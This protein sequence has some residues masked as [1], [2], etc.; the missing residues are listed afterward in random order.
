MPLLAKEEHQR[1]RQLAAWSSRLLPD[2]LH[3]SEYQILKGH[4]TNAQSAIYLTIR[5]DILRLWTRN[6]LVHVSVNEIL[7]RIKDKR[8]HSLVI[9][10]HEW[11]ARH[12]YINFGCIHIWPTINR[13]SASPAKQQRIVIIGAGVSGLSTARQLTNIILQFPER[14]CRDRTQM[15]PRL[16]ILE[17]RQ[18]IGGRVYSHALKNQVPGSLPHGLANTA[19]MGAQIITGFH[20]GNPLD[21]LVRGQLTLEYHLMKDNMMLYDFDG[22]TIDLEADTKVQNLFNDLLEAASSHGWHINHAPKTVHSQDIEMTSATM[23]QETMANG[24]TKVSFM[25]IDPIQIQFVLTMS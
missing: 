13:P 7:E 19:E 6:P 23:K 25:H 18:R 16:T 22:T 21:A 8:L 1:Q 4:L 10:A 9:F 24:S 12:G 14:W 17:G 15:L 20:H 5:N 11:L 2:A 3:I